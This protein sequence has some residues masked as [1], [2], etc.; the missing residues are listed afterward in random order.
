MPYEF[1]AK[2]KKEAAKRRQHIVRL[3]ASGKT[4]EEIGAMLSM[5]RQRAHALY[6]EAG[7][8]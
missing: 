8:K 4:F 3:R 1:Q 6:R 2:V 7:G 5:S